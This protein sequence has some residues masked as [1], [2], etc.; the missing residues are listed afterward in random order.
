MPTL[1][2]ESAKVERKLWTANEFLDWL[3]P[4]VHADPINGRKFM[5][6]AVN[7][8]HAKL[9]NFLDRFL[10][11]YLETSGIGGNLFREVVAVRLTSRNV[12]LPD[13]SWFSPA[14]SAR[15][16]LAHASFAPAWVAE[17]L[18][19]RTAARD[20]GPK[21]AAYERNGSNEYWI[22]DPETLAHR[23]YAREDDL[24]VEFAQ[25]EE[26]I[27]SREIAGFYV[28]RQWLDPA[29]LPKVSD[30]LGEIMANQ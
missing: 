15:L 12:F 27:R 8:R 3:Q 19:P 11:M 4:G 30:C 14:Q 6:S 28:R 9:L 17:A 16:L 20:I 7:S 13:L 18:S 2:S 23:F 5:H 1:V 22:L 26:M 29:A 21:F 24:F 10:G 25:C